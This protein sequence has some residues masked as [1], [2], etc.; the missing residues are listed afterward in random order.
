MRDEPIPVESLVRVRTG[1]AVRIARR[2]F[3]WIGGLALGPLVALVLMLALQ[4]SNAPGHIEI[5]KPAHPVVS[6][7]VEPAVIHSTPEQIRRHRQAVQ[8]AAAVTVSAPASVRI[9]T[10]DPD[11]VILLVGNQR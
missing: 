1:V 3:L 8:R 9:E 11:V 2:R 4:T 10:D 5:R 6:T 7:P